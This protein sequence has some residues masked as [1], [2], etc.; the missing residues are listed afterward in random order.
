MNKEQ[1]SQCAGL[2]RSFCSNVLQD[3]NSTRG[4]ELRHVADCLEEWNGLVLGMTVFNPLT[5][6]E[7]LSAMGPLAWDMAHEIDTPTDEA[8][9]SF[10]CF[11]M[12]KPVFDFLEQLY[13]AKSD[14]V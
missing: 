1:A 5:K 3:P 9:D 8:H 2:L 12:I 11:R 4:V 14:L 7:V 6:E 13:V 10:A